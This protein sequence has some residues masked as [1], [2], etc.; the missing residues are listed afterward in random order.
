MASSV[1][2]L[3]VMKDQ[4]TDSIGVSHPGPDTLV[5]VQVK[6]LHIPILHCSDAEVI[7][8]RS[9]DL[10]DLSLLSELRHGGF[11]KVIAHPL[12]QLATL[13][14]EH[15]QEVGPERDKDR[16]GV[17]CQPTRTRRNLLRSLRLLLQIERPKEVVCCVVTLYLVT[18]LRTPEL[19]AIVLDPSLD[20]V[21]GPPHLD[22]PICTYTQ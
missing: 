19:L 9:N 14:I 11:I 16:S 7:V 5:R 6:D 17:S 4:T 18:V 22:C 21:E 12:S 8:C 2:D 13:S 20:R 15:A 1:E 10:V 3:V